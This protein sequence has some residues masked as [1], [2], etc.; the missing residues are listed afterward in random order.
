MHLDVSLTENVEIGA[1]RVLNQ[2]ALEVET[3]D[4]G[5]EVRNLRADD[6]P[7]EWEFS[8]PMVDVNL[9]TTDYDSVR[10]LWALSE[11]GLHTFNF[12]D[13]VDDTVYRVRFAS[14]LQ[15]TA[16]AGHLRHIDTFT[17]RELLETSPEPT[18]KPAITGSATVGGTLTLSTGTYTGS[19]TSYAR[20]WTANGVDIGGATGTTYVP[21]SGDAGKLISGYVDA[22]DANG[23]V[24]RT[25]ANSVGPI[26]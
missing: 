7:R 20:Q 26:V 1:M 15:I 24:T 5:F 12:N 19:P 9:D 18:V 14:K 21:V 11:R 22:T 4:G 17:L 3:T 13:F 6:E 25:W 23:G 16:P 8:L 10:S 2:D